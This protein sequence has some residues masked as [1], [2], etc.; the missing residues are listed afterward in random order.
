MTDVGID[1]WSTLDD[2]PADGAGQRRNDAPWSSPDWS[3]A[4]DDPL[5][6]PALPLDVFP[7]AWGGWMLAAAERA[8]APVDY[9]A[10]SALTAI[11]AAIGNRR[12]GQVREEWEHPPV[13]FSALVGDPSS[14]KSP[15]M[16]AVTT[17]IGELEET[18]NEDWRERQRDHAARVK[19]AKAQRAA[20]EK[21]AEAAVKKSYA[22]PRMPEAALDP[23]PLDRRRLIVDSVTTERLAAMV[24][25]NPA[26][27]L[28]AS[29]ELARWLAGMDRYSKGSGGADR[30]FWL[31]AHGGGRYTVDR[32]G[33]DE[34]VAV[35]VR[36]L[37]VG[38]LGGIQPDRL[39][40]ALLSGDDDGLAAR[41][42]FTWP[43]R[44]PPRPPEGVSQRAFIAA[45][46]DRLVSLPWDSNRPVLLSFH[47][48]AEARMDALRAEVFEMEA[49]AAGIMRSWLGKLPGQA[50]R[51]A[52]IFA[53]M[54]WTAAPEHTPSPTFISAEDVEAAIALLTTYF[55]PMARRVFGSSA[56]PEDERDA[57]TLARWLLR[58]RAIPA[59]VNA[60]DLRH[61]TGGPSLPDASRMRAA[62]D[63]LAECGWVRPAADREPGQPGRPR[64][65]YAVNPA[66]RA[67]PS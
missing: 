52:V 14:G 60:R 25:A 12:W 17:P 42:L 45:A 34:V 29:D 49:D 56:L 41:F 16:R 35:V 65:D 57:R 64:A 38:V 8:G 18:L 21:E 1:P 2:A 28:L 30:A 23:D 50:V 40:A 63:V 31:E 37:T 36:N 46:L 48:R 10:V 9:V 39:A 54:R 22:P 47:A 66:L 15:A 19:E 4:S 27:L 24:K 5:P 61:M 67:R 59:T 43:A 7:G 55:L 13:L 3:L 33:K 51:L 6:P 20:W 44:V 62:L 32:V 53:H 26:G 58:Q 11:G